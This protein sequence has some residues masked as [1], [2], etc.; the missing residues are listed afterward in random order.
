[1]TDTIQ[2]VEVPIDEYVDLN[3][4]SGLPAGTAVVITN[5]STGWC[6]LQVTSVK[7]LAS[8]TAGEP[9]TNLPHNTAI[10]FITAG[11]STVWAK[12]TGNTK[13]LLS[14]QDNT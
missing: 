7:P 2:D 13:V 1:M 9:I 6:R 10:K 5:K 11:E 12:A 3:T 8:S 4:L 14:V